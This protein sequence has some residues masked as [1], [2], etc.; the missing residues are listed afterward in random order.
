MN[1]V[2]YAAYVRDPDGN[3]LCAYYANNI[4]IRPRCMLEAP[5]IP[6]HAIAY[7][8]A[9]SLWDREQNRGRFLADRQRS[10][11]SFV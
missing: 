2:F 6:P 3:K 5:D 8:V 9:R 10:P 4:A 1:P 11:R 7:A